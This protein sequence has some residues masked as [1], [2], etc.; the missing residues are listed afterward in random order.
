[1]GSRQNGPGPTEAPV[2]AVYICAIS[3]R[4]RS[5]LAARVKAALTSALGGQN[6]FDSQPLMGTE[7]FGVFGLEGHK[8]PT[9]IFWLGAMDPVSFAAAQQAGKVLPG[10][11][12]SHFQPDPEPTLRTGVVAMTTVAISLLQK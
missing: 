6:V 1:M 5:S 10:M 4:R 12:T 11:H 9:V 3:A 2:S 8:I 7:D